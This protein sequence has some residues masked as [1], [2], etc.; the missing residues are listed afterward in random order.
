VYG[1]AADAA[2]PQAIAKIYAAKGRPSDH[3]VIVHVAGAADVPRWAARVPPY[4]QALIDAC[5]PGPLTLVLPRADGVPDAV[6]GGQDTVGVR[7]PA[8]PLAQALLTACRD[9]GV[10]GLAAPSANRFGRISPTTAAHVT[11]EFG[12]GLMVLD[13]G[14]CAVG[15]ESTIVDCTGNAPALLRPGAVSAQ[16]VARITGLALR[17][18]G[19]A[20]PRASGTLPAHYQPATPARL[21][22]DAGLIDGHAG[23]ALYARAKPPRFAGAFRAAPADVAAYA[24]DLYAAL[25]ALDALGCDEIIIEPPHD[26]QS[27]ALRAAIMDRLARATSRQ[28]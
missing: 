23:A 2:N 11:D 28:R 26:G 16:D 21:I 4:A 5:W 17:A 9:L 25:R 22:D 8:H 19:R 13:G 7:C 15:I 12:S 3:P 27:D 20:S 18:A 6:T 10:M 1:L 14:P 24:Q